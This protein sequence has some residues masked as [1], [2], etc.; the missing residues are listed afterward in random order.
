VS[1]S[2][3]ER[4]T[5]QRAAGYD[6]AV[7]EKRNRSKRRGASPNKVVPLHE[8]AE[9]LRASLDGTDLAILRALQANARATYTEIGRAVGLSA[10]SVHERVNRLET[11]GVIRGYHAEVDPEVLG[12]EVLSL[13]SV[14]SSDSIDA[15]RQVETVY[16]VA[17]EDSY[18]LV[19]R[20]RSIA[21]LSEVLQLLQAVD[22]VAR[23]RTSVVLATPV[24]RGPVV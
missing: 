13:V 19:V 6:P 14:V 11:R 16:K 8:G 22:G 7:P 24:Q 21:E 23:T 15:A 12:L 9:A 10:A 2:D 18:L 17:G 4:G 5:W 20:T 1:R 3:L